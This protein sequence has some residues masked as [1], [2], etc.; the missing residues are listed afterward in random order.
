M[1]D[2]KWIRSNPDALDAMLIK[3]GS[4]AVSSSLMEMDEKRRSLM[5]E[6]QALQSRRNSLSKEVGALKSKGEDA[7][8]LFEEM[9]TVGPKLK[10]LEEQVRDM[11][12]QFENFVAKLPN[13]LAD[14]VPEG[15]DD[16]ENAL[17]SSWG[18]PRVLD[19]E[20]KHHADLGEELGLFDFETA[21]KI[22]GS[23]FAWVQGDLAR[24]ERALAMFMLDKQTQQNGFTEVNPPLLVTPKTMFGTGQL[25][26]FGEDAFYTNDDRDLM[27]ISTSEVS[28]TNYMQERIVKED[29]LPLKFTAYTPCFRK[30]AGSAGK[31]TRGYIRMHQFGKVEMVQIV[32][33]EKSDEALEFMRECA[34][35]ILRDLKLPYRVMTLCGGDTG[36]SAQ[37]T[38]DL[39]V[40][41]PEQDT[42][43]EISSCSKC[44]DFQARRMNGRFKDKDG[45]NHFVH[46][47]NGSGLATGRTLVAVMENYQQAD[48][49]IEVPEVLQPYMGGQT[50][51][52]AHGTVDNVQ[53]LGA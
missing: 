6:Q 46:T 3:R 53:K 34:E 2:I 29:D 5:T 48:G 47:L 11:D 32:H 19:F 1:L 31:D 30:E 36:F 41:L 28:L 49:S 17:V 44:G 13:I 50:I 20:P 27:L 14:D 12:E 43:R 9:K 24:L 22:S 4:E 21:G 33:P 16:T 25:P 7:T 35:G 26:K 45:K 51:I 15:A 18:E 39:E 8:H 42:Y 37:K 40:W 23:R 10:E 38:Y 52:R